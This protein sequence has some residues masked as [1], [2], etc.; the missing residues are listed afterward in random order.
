MS[1][2]QKL[3]DN[4]AKRNLLAQLRTRL[5]NERTLL[6]YVR[7]SLY[8]LVGGIALLRVRELENL[9]YFGYLAFAISLVLLLVGLN[10]FIV[11]KQILSKNKKRRFRKKIRF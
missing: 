9:Q 5:A 7:T 3:P 4:P 10:R 11:L 2:H 6:S 8:F 1:D